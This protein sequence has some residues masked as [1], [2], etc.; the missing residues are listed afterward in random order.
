MAKKPERLSAELKLRLSEELRKKIELAAKK[1]FDGRGHSLNA[2]MIDRLERSFGQGLFEEILTLTYGPTTAIFL[3]EANKR[4]M[5]N[6]KEGQKED[7]L[8]AVSTFLDIMIE[9]M[10]AK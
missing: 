4:G 3:I 6:V 8:E 9:Q 2:E 7:M 1:R 5:L 10:R